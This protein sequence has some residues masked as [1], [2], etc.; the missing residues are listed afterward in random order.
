MWK[1]L[2]P[3]SIKQCKYL[4]RPE[5]FICAVG[6][7]FHLG[8]TTTLG[9]K[10]AKPHFTDCCVNI[11]AFDKG[12]LGFDN[13]LFIALF[14]WQTD[15]L[16]VLPKAALDLQNFLET[17]NPT[18]SLSTT[19]NMQEVVAPAKEVMLS[20]LTVS[21]GCI[22][23]HWCPKSLI[24]LKKCILHIL[25]CLTHNTGASFSIL[26]I[27]YGK[28]KVQIHWMKAWLRWSQG[29]NSHWFLC[30]ENFT[31]VL[32]VVLYCSWLRAKG[33]FEKALLPIVMMNSSGTSK[34]S[35]CVQEASVS[36]LESL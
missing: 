29:Q 8:P 36:I 3:F 4:K 21:H 5:S 23:S 11:I 30:A 25:D 10:T 14:P 27:H 12:C 9:F 15:Q 18:G 6:K 35:P 1:Y 26:F 16:F 19:E 7:M 32:L 34:H 24:L 31:S 17:D 13:V 2:L 20:S 22:S 28:P 33:A